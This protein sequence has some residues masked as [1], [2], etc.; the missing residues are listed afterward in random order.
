[1]IMTFELPELPYAKDALS[2]ISQKKP[3]SFITANIIALRDQPQQTYL[4]ELSG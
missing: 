1:M 3:L 2:L 4:K